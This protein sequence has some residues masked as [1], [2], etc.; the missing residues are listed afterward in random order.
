MI[1]LSFLFFFAFAAVSVYH[2]ELLKG[3]ARKDEEPTAA[4]L[5]KAT[6]V[7]NLLLGSAIFFAVLSLP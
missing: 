3:I 1:A 5:A 7:R 6:I 2:V 4:G